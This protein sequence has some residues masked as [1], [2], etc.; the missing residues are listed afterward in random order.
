[1][2][3][4]EFAE[5]CFPSRGE[6]ACK[7]HDAIQLIG[8]SDQERPRDGRHCPF[9]ICFAGGQVYSFDAACCMFYFVNR[10]ENISNKEGGKNA[11]IRPLAQRGKALIWKI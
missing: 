1:L 7:K 10:N 9:L 2:P 4:T 5:F 8:D 6:R 11:S 3:V